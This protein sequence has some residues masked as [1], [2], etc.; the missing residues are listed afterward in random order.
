MKRETAY[1]HALDSEGKIVSISEALKGKN[2]RCVE[3]GQEFILRE[4]PERQKHFA[5]KKDTGCA[6]GSETFLHSEFK[7]RLTALLNSRIKEKGELGVS[8]E[9]RECGAK[10]GPKNLM[11]RVASVKELTET[12]ELFDIN[13]NR[14]GVIEIICTD[15]PEEQALFFRPH[16]KETCIQIKL[17]DL[18]DLD[19]V[20]E[21][22]EKPY[23]VDYCLDSSCRLM[24]K[25]EGETDTECALCGRSFRSRYTGGISV[26][27]ITV[28]S[29]EKVCPSCRNNPA[30]KK[31]A[32]RKPARRRRKG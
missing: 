19:R 20:E 25:E 12:V 23:S 15:A 22:L 2:Y 31:P 9:C 4:G 17:W 16:S 21:K 7:K 29:F 6:G 30:I 1:Q 10:W 27:G 26:F 11:N 28:D 14:I 8:W 5:H 18:K 13:R 3:C 24:E 32:K